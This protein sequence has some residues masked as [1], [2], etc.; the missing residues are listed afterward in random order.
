MT[1]A[2]FFP[3]GFLACFAGMWIGISFLF[4]W[5]SGWRGLSSRYRAA[6]KPDGESLLWSSADLGGV[7]FRSCL[8]FTL[9]AEG[10]Y[11]EPSLLFRLFMPPL[12][13]PWRDVRFEGLKTILFFETS[14]F[15][16]GGEAG[17]VLCVRRRT[18]DR[19]RPYFSA[20]SRAAAASGRLYAGEAVSRWV[21]IIMAAAAAVGILAQLR[22]RR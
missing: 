21:W 8:N 18:G 19:F 14:C 1:H 17:P 6:A 16:L 9:S 13:I 12:L 3:Y 4:S 15:R 10:L 2:A 11:A 22:V 20:E 5:M 7:T